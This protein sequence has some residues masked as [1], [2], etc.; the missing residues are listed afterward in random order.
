MLSV[1]NKMN[2]I[3]RKYLQQLLLLL[4]LLMGSNV[5]F[6]QQAK[7]Y[8]EAIIKG[9]KNFEADKLLDAKA[10]YQMALK[11]KS[12]DEYAKKQIDKIVEEM[13]SRIDKEDKYLEII[14]VADKLFDNN[15]LDEAKEE[16]S[17]AMAVIAGDDYAKEQIDK[18]ESIQKNEKENLEN[19]N[20]FISLGQQNIKDNN[21][22]DAISNFKKAGK[23]F[24]DNKQPKQLIE[25]AKAAKTEFE[26]KA[27]VYTNEVEMANRYINVKNYVEAV[28][29]LKTALEIFP[30]EWAVEEEI[31]KYEPL[32]AKQVEYNK[33]IEIADELYVNKNY[34]AARKAYEDATELWPEN[35]YTADMISRIDEQLGEKMANL[36]ANYSKS[37]KAADSLFSIKD[38]D[39]AGAEYNLALS[40]KPDEK[41]PKSK[42]DEIQGIYA[43]EKAKLEQQYAS[44]IS[45]ADSLFNLKNYDASKEKYNLALSIRP[46]DQHPKDQLKEIENQLNLLAEQKQLNEKFDGIIAAADAFVKDKNYEEAINKYKEALQVKDDEYPKQRITEIEN[47]IANAAKQKEIDAK[48][49]NQMSL[50]N[51]LLEEKNYADARTA[52]L[53]AAEI[54][55][56]ESEPK[57]KIENIDNILR[58]RQ[59]QAELDAKYQKL[60]AKSD[61]LIKE[62][63][64]EAAIVALNE[65]LKLKPD[66]VFATN[67]L[68]EVNK[69]KVEY[70][71]QQE[72][73]KQYEAAI[74]EADEMLSQKE[75][76]QAKVSYTAA[77]N[78][79]PSDKYATKKIGEI[80]II[81]KQMEAEINRKYDETIVKADNLFDA[82]NLSEAIVQ[83]KIASSLKPEEEYPK[84]KIAEANTLIEEK[85]K[86]VRNEYNLAI[87]D[88]D[89]LY[90]AKIYD[91]AITAYQKANKIFPEESYPEEM[92]KKITN[93]IETNAIVDVIKTKTTINSKNT[94]K[95][96]FEPIRID[97]RKSNYIL[98]KARNLGTNEFKMIFGYGIGTAKNGGFVVSVPADSESHDYIIRVGNQYKWFSEDNNWISMYPENGDIEISLLRI[99]KS[100]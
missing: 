95:V 8:D 30:E 83:Y 39:K 65:A 89:K 33:Q 74:K 93:L 92:I 35:S 56:L 18:I 47:V 42:L 85:L 38:Y 23:I 36:E 82:S 59:L 99:S 50:A 40:L 29:H 31:A 98:V 58:E 5:V 24:P 37:I 2:F 54:K 9:D 27:E 100:D 64:F 53:A 77:L 46:D 79:K 10:Y 94:E 19:F 97:V 26:S 17:K 21:Y 81:L 61:S 72:L 63:N 76:S 28:K 14:M 13:A 73:I 70:E 32:A 52:Y 62:N 3:K 57:E 12:D 16:Y 48:Y 75:Y 69:Q 86:L 20:K 15:K 1:L 6:S 22:D 49:D 55:P 60:I 91:K 4:V 43:K 44:I 68:E 96:E 80:N 34:S 67:N 71:K 87:A 25:E 41:Y 84:T 51:R 45:S 11:F 66:D 7:T 78:I 90:A 88:A